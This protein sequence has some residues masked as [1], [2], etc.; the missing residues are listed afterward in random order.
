[1]VRGRIAETTPATTPSTNQMIAAPIANDA[2]TGSASLITC[3]TGS[4]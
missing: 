1:M 2:V 3:V 4:W